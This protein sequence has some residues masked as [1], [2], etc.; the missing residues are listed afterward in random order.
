[1]EISYSLLIL[2]LSDNVLQQVNDKDTATKVWLKLEFLYMTKTLSN[3]IY[4]K[5]QLFGF[6]MDPSKTLEENLDDFKVI[7]IGLTNIDEKISDEN[8]AILLLNSLLES[9]KDMKIVIKYGRESL[10]LENALVALRSRDLEVKKDKKSNTAK[11][12]QVQG[13]FD[14][15]PQ[16]RGRGVTRSQSRNR[17][18]S[19]TMSCW[20]CKN[21][22]HLR[23]QCPLR[24]K[25]YENY[26]NKIDV[27]NFSDGYE[28]REGLTIS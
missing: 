19:R 7:T 23:K 27:E 10:S 18:S 6:K 1:M 4:L 15:R 11:G 12:L 17:G 22:G 25:G 28:S 24:K 9:Y 16:S 3:K 26:M 8:Q 14:R 20:F 2:N 13:K 5:E 21:E